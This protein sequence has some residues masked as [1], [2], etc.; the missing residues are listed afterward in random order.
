[1][2]IQAPT[3]PTSG[4]FAPVA[5]KRI[6]SPIASRL[7][8][9]VPAATIDRLFDSHHVEDLRLISA[10]AFIAVRW[11]LILGLPLAIESAVMSLWSTFHDHASIWFWLRVIF[12]GAGYFLSFFG[13]VLAIFGAVLAW[14]YQV[15]SA[16][17]GVV[18]LF[19][20][21]ISTLCRV[22][23]V[24]ETARRYVDNFE[25]GPSAEGRTSSPSVSAN[26]FTSQE[27][28][29][30]VFENNTRDLQTLEARVV[31]NI[32]AFY[33]Y[34]KAVR[35]SLRAL[36]EITPQSAESQ[37]ASNKSAIEEPWHEAMLNVI[38]MLYLG[39][40]SARLAVDDLVEYE[41][42]KAE[43]TVVILISEL[44]A[45]GLLAR[46]YPDKEDMH[47]ERLMLREP[48]YRT[49]VPAVTR[50]V[51]AGRSAV[52][53]CQAETEAEVALRISLWEPAGRLLPEL[54]RRYDAVAKLM[55]AQSQAQIVIPERSLRKAETA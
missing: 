36:N 50:A 30:P 28:Y 51:E 34:M 49:L 37:P 25:R 16:R 12:Q 46:K 23:T 27:S 55:H 6:L 35:E 40:E 53:I 5:I 1:M 26:Q 21:E 11:V 19:A 45:Y 15:G 17:L 39:L 52:R 22:A 24:V 2:P 7:R 43:R 9:G 47:H 42:E 13:P 41:P 20:C 31:V 33:T 3:I 54:Q 29:F 18:D 48:T 14:I 44:E 32:T 38:F 10:V 4:R 8:T